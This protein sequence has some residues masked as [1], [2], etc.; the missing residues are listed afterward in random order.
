MIQLFIKEN[1]ENNQR[2]SVRDNRGQILYL[3]EGR[4]GRKGDKMSIYKLNGECLMTMKQQKLS[5]I[6]V[7][8]LFENNIR[9]GT[10]RKHPGLFGLRDSYFT[11]HPHR[12]LITGDFED[13]Y[14][15]AHKDNELLMECEK[16]LSNG[17][18]FYELS[19]KHEEDAV[20]SALITT[21]FDHY[22]RKRIEEEDAHYFSDEDYELGFFNPFSLSLPKTP[23]ECIKTR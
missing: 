6:P 22:S 19:I 8:E 11:L 21:L 15:T 1:V 12:W 9:T 20:I 10:M 17:I 5:P 2:M 16:D 4:W 7:F 23:K 14:F 3:I 18:T 13:L